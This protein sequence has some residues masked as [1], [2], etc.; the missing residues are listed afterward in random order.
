MVK[1]IKI[2]GYD[3]EI[4]GIPQ[5]EFGGTDCPGRLHALKQ[6]ILVD[7]SQNKQCQESS[8]LHEI[9]EALNYHL[10][11]NISHQSIMSLEAGLYQV[12]KDN[13]INLSKLLRK[14]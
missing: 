13:G 6:I 2:L 5:M 9:I 7:L 12:L 8:L 3:Y 14:K 11:T 10:E 4:R 1:K